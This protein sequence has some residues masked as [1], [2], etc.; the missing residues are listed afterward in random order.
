VVEKPEGKSVKKLKRWVLLTLAGAL[1]VLVG[2]R[3]KEAVALDP[4]TLL[5]AR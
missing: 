1:V 5:S 4:D 3:A 2:S